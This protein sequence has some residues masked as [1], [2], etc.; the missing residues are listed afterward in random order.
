VTAAGIALKALNLCAGGWGRSPAFRPG[1][2]SHHTSVPLDGNVSSVYSGSLAH[3][4]SR[5]L[6][7]YDYVSAYDHGTI[8]IVVGASAAKP[9]RRFKRR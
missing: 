4:I 2:M 9:L 5:L 6:G 8:D 3:V 1:S 7:G